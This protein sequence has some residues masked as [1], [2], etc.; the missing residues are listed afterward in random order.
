MDVTKIE[1][2]FPVPVKLTAEKQKAIHDIVY[3]LCKE[4]PP[5]GMVMWP[6]GVGCKPTYIPLTAEEAG[7][8]GPEFDDQVFFYRMFGQ[9]NIVLV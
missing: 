2:F 6:F 8:R 1:I 5:D 9:A 3:D 7:E 4:N